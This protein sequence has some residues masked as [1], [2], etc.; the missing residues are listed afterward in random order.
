[1]MLVISKKINDKRSLYMFT[2]TTVSFTNHKRVGLCPT[3]NNNK[4]VS[5]TLFRKEKPWIQKWKQPHHPWK[6]VEG[7]VTQQPPVRMKTRANQVQEA[8]AKDK[9]EAVVEEEAVTK[10]VEDKAGASTAHHTCHQLET[11]RDKYMILERN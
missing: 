9:A 5:S 4:S 8:E 2:T 1:M 7:K 3:R 10:D 11:S 6:E